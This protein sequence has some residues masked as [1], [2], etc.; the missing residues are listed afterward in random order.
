MDITG[1][2]KMNKIY[3]PGVKVNRIKYFRNIK[4]QYKSSLIYTRLGYEKTNTRLEPDKRIQID[5]WINE[6]EALCNVCVIYRT[7]EVTYDEKG[8]IVLDGCKILKSSSLHSLLQNSREAVL[9]AA[10]SGLGITDE[11]KRLQQAGEMAKALVYDA[12]AS[13]ITDAGLDWLMGFLKQKLIREGKVL[14]DMRYSPGYG[15]L[16]L[17]CQDV[18]FRMLSLKEW[19]IE[20]TEKYMLV[21]EKSV[22]AIAGI[23]F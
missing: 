14:T 10:T 16:D 9:M 19:G 4:V 11:I 8:I 21:P 13:E 3:V 5:R 20:L 12:A 23:E 7:A 2:D 17:S 18:F 1:C 22:T 6:A 15:D